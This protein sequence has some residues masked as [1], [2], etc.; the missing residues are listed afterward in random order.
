ME[1][2]AAILLMIGCSGDLV[3]C[4][5]IAVPTFAYETM[6]ECDSDLHS[7]R[8]AA[9][10]TYPRMFA[11]CL[12]VDPLLVEAD[13]ELVWDIEDGKL[14]ASLEPLA[15]PQAT[16]AMSSGDAISNRWE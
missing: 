9:D 11:E 14:V 13:A 15:E 5:E 2:I 8:S 6:E 12:S 16:I 3:K 10:G 1:H 7:V 4:E